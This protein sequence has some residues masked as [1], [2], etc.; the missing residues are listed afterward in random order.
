MAAT[1]E[2]LRSENNAKKAASKRRF[3]EEYDNAKLG[4]GGARRGKKK[5]GDDGDG[6]E[7]E[8]EEED[9]DEHLKEAQRLREEQ[10]E[11]NRREFEGEGDAARRR[12]EGFRPG[13]YVRVLFRGLP[14]EFMRHF[15]PNL[16]VIVG[17]LLPHE[18]SVGLMRCRVK[19]HR[20]HNKTLK[21]NDPLVFSV[22]WRRFQ[23]M[24]IYCVEDPNER[25]R[26]LKY[27]PDHMHCQAVVYGPACPPN[28]GLLAF[29]SLSNAAPGFR[30]SL[31]GVL[32][33]LDERFEVVKKLKLVGHPDK[34]FRKTAF[35]KGMF[36]SALEVARFEGASVRTVSGIRGQ[37]K[38]AAGGG[39]AGRFRAT[40]EDK[41]LM[42][43]TVFCRLWVPV[44]AN[45]YYNPVTSLLDP[46]WRGMRTTAQLRRDAQIP[47]PVNKDSLYKPIEREP[48]FFNPMPV[49]KAL[50][51]QLP[52]ASKPKLKAAKK[53][54]GYL[55]KRAVVL[56][57]QERKKV[58]LMQALNT[59]RKEKT[60]LRRQAGQ[61]KREEVLK[62]KAK[63]TGAF[64]D[65]HRADKKRHH[66]EQG[67]EQA[68]KR[69]RL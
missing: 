15:R 37:I 1:W 66:R 38:K 34:V 52:F 39:D 23:S 19:R 9:L 13:S 25:H 11:R 28:T 18:S 58:A 35:I 7:A 67:K 31:T 53:R 55:D 16:P 32:L 40:F 48:R 51:A 64:A 42:S 50:Q 57:P 3:D 56:E 33:E 20:W 36:N 62:R 60:K 5:G 61:K 46:E 14:A 2:Q 45:R 30:I 8:E 68:R 63:E 44:E 29:Q 4:G 10:R 6:D 54:K 17:G 12:L 49:P 47:V 59:I 26:F 24:P 43:D 21:S 65:I 41:I 27:T 22:G 69:Q